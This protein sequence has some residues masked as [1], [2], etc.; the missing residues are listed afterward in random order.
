MEPR[1]C[2]HCGG[3]N[4]RHVNARYCSPECRSRA[5]SERK[6]R[7]RQAKLGDRSCVQ[8]GAP[9][10]VKKHPRVRFCSGACATAWAEAEAS[11]KR[12]AAR[13]TARSGRL[14]SAG[15]GQA[16]PPELTANA[17]YCSEACKREV[18]LED[19]RS[20]AT[21][22]MRTYKYGITP[23]RWD[24]QMTAQ[25]GRCAICRTDEWRA[26]GR[27]NDGRPHADHDH[28][29]TQPRLRGI[30]CGEE[31]LGLGKFGDDPLR[32][33]AAARYLLTALAD[34]AGA[35]V[36][37]DDRGLLAKSLLA[38]AGDDPVLLRAADDY[39]GAAVV[40]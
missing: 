13:I 3:P 29:R 27:N 4:P 24:A 23:E 7:A 6:L 35:G 17:L 25:G 30:L 26:P 12:T 10:E 33:L 1:T 37:C 19:R 14:C 40:S 38:L 11:A 20:R 36:P 16:I 28:G 15:C 22:Y 32:L 31:N 5:Y 9:I 21:T 8:C 18:N 34:P 39:L 2:G